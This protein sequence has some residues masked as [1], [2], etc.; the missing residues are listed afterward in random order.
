[1][2]DVTPPGVARVTSD[3][4]RLVVTFDADAIDLSLPSLPPQDFLLAIQPGD[5]PTTVRLMTGPKF[6]MHRVTT[7]QPDASSSRVV[8]DLLPPG[9]ESLAPAQPPPN[10]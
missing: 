8:I 6:G 5:T 10:P 7:S 1:T 9:T 3:P 2:F 4:G